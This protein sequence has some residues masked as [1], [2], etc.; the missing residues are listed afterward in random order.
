LLDGDQVR[1]LRLFLRHGQQD[2]DGDGD[3]EDEE[4]TRFIVEVELSRLGDLQLD[5]LVR[6]KRLDLILRSRVPLPEFMR[7]D[8]MQIFHDANEITGYRG[9]IGF[10]SSIDWKA[11]PIEAPDA[12]TPPGVMA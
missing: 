5:G 12:D 1:Q 9:S 7:R 11:M 10:Q 6:E 4:K 8:I 2:G 3:G